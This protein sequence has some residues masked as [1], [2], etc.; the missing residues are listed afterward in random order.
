MISARARAAF[1]T[2][3]L[4]SGDVYLIIQ[5][6]CDVGA[7]MVSSAR[8]TVDPACRRTEREYWEAARDIVTKLRAGYPG[9]EPT[10]P[11]WPHD[12]PWERPL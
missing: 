7:R 10:Y 4:R 5:T 11:E 12:L 9:T 1:S 8:A 2:L 3:G 6:M